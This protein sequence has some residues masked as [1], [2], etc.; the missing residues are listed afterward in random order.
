MKLYAE[1]RWKRAVQVVGDAGLLLWIGVWSFVGFRIHDLFAL[2][3]VPARRI[4]RAGGELEAQMTEVSSSVSRL[5]VVGDVLREPFARAAGAGEYFR[6]AGAAQA[7]TLEEVAVWV[8]VAVAFVPILLLSGR[9]LPHRFRWVRE[10]SA[11]SLLRGRPESDYL[12]AMRA[13]GRRSLREISG[14]T[15]DP[16]ADLREGRFHDLAALELRHLGLRALR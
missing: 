15:T 5:A 2:L 12:F 3:A 16:T 11:A 10:A 13:V 7:Q 14:V 6:S 8:G 4:S 1:T 9:Y